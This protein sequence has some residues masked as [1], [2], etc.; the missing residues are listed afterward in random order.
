MRL[1]FS[2]LVGLQQLEV[3]V[4]VVRDLS[5]DA[6]PVD[7]V[8]GGEMVRLVHFCVGEEGLHHVLAVVEGAFHGEAVYVRV[9]HGCHLRFLDG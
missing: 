2:D 5:Q 4:E 6:G 3:R 8:D 9:E 7:A 1:A